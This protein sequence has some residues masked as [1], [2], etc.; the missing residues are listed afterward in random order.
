M[1]AAS[2]PSRSSEGSFGDEGGCAGRNKAGRR[3]PARATTPATRQL[4][5][6]P[7]MKA[8]EAATWTSWASACWPE[9]A[10]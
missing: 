3:A 10:R 7:R 8:F 6:I 4:M 9:L 1:L 2:V 5:L